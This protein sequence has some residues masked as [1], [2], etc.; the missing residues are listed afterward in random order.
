M[1]QARLRACADLIR[2][3]A[4]VCDVGTDHALLPVFL[5]RQGIVGDVIAADIAQGPLAAAEATIARYGLSGRI[6]TILSDG[7]QA[8]PPEGLTDIV[9]AGMGGETII[10][11]LETCPW[12]LAGKSLIL[13]P[14]TKAPDLRE[15]LYAHGFA[16]ER[17]VCARE[18]KFLYAVMRAVYTGEK[19]LPGAVLRH[20][21]RL[22]LTDADCLAYA[23]RQYLRVCKARDGSGDAAIIAEAQALSA[24]LEVYHEDRGDL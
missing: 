13:Q 23:E 17:E 22:D 14:M 4:H 6:H 16:I 3:G 5:Y 24:V 21:G 15:W 9:I 11:I 18:G 1:L 19:L 8:V 10:H 2:P 12:S 20:F 7:L